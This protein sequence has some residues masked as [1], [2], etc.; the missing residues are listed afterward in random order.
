MVA[1]YRNRGIGS[2]LIKTIIA[3]LEETYGKTMYVSIASQNPDA[4]R[5]YE[6]FG[7]RKC[8]EYMYVVKEQQ[9]LEYIFK[10]VSTD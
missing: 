10:R 1:D 3:W 8:D 9:D 6:R 2:K 4:L 5:M 7:F